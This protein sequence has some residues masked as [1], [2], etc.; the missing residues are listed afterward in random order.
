MLRPEVTINDIVFIIFMITL[1]IAMYLSYRAGKLDGYYEG[2][3]A[4]RQ[5]ERQ[6]R[7]SLRRC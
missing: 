1:C 5:A 2:C 4:R 7:R 3:K 6:L